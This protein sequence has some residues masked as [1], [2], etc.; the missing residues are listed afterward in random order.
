MDKLAANISQAGT[1][2]F[3]A[4]ADDEPITNQQIRNNM[5]AWIFDPRDAYEYVQLLQV[6]RFSL[7]KDE[8]KQNIHLDTVPQPMEI[9]KED[10]KKLYGLMKQLSEEKHAKKQAQYQK[11]N[12]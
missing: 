11:A 10:A 4:P 9:S 7:T 5:V 1:F 6:E 2:L 8:Q 12:K 3:R